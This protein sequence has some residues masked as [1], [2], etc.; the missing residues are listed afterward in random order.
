MFALSPLISN[1]FAFVGSRQR[2]KHWNVTKWN[3]H[4]NT[5][6]QMDNG[7]QSHSHWMEQKRSKKRGGGHKDCNTN[8]QYIFFVDKTRFPSRNSLGSKNA[9]SN[10]WIC[11]RAKIFGMESP[12]R[13]RDSSA[14]WSAAFIRDWRKTGL[15][16]RDGCVGAS[17]DICGRWPITSDWILDEVINLNLT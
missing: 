16:G 12:G 3:C 9:H 6:I 11:R 1:K 7:E 17:C 10:S 8:N 2:R 13:T 4:C 5:R 14:N 15:S